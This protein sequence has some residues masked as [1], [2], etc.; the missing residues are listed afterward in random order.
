M[1]KMRK[2]M[3]KEVKKLNP[4]IDEKSNA[5]TNVFKINDKKRSKLS[6]LP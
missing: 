5:V 3:N 2:K 4:P 1:E 6:I